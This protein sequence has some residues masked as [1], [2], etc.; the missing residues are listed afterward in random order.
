[1]NDHFCQRYCPTQE[2]IRQKATVTRGKQY[3][4]LNVSVWVN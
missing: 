4:H 2:K 3:E 1:M